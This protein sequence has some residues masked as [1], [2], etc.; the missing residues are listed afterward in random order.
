MARDRG[1]CM[2]ITKS[3]GMLLRSLSALFLVLP[4][5]TH[6][7]VWFV[8]WMASMQT[9]Q[10]ERMCVFACAHAHVCALYY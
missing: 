2:I 1:G 10:R 7:H 4:A 8:L 5:S 9:R 6:Q 3:H